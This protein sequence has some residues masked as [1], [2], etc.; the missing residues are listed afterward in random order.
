[1]ILIGGSVV[2]AIGLVFCFFGYKLARF[3]LPLCGTLVLESIVYLYI[4]SLFQMNTLGTWLFFGGTSVVI[5]ILLFFFN[6]ISGFFTGLLG[7]AMFLIFIVYAFQLQSVPY[8]YPAGM[9]I[10]V[11]AGLLTVVY[12]RVGVIIST[13][14]LG[15]CT[16]AFFGLYIYVEHINAADFIMYRNVLVPL[17]QY[18]S[19]NAVLVL[20]ASAVLA[21]LSVVIQ[22]FATGKT[23]VLSK[24]KDDKGFRPRS[25]KTAD[26]SDQAF[27]PGGEDMYGLPVSPRKEKRY[28]KFSG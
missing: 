18:L 4:Y 24:N 22:V 11:V 14:L 6:R 10:S 26:L 2:I 9:T 13:S 15:A 5:F 7:S 28:H 12:Q 25:K 21:V 1:M 8:V 27:E 17:Q 3:L 19:A 23:Q 20:G 16:A